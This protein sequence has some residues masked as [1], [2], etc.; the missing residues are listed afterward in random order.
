MNN[1]GKKGKIMKSTIVK[2]GVGFLLGATAI[3]GVATAANSEPI[4]V[5]ACVDKKTQVMYLAANDKCISS[6]TLV[7]LGA[8]SIDVKSIAALVTPSVFY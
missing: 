7:S 8:S 5:K 2:V 4:G 3:G 6:R 1:Y